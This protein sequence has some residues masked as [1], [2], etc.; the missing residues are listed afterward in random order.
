MSKMK[1]G[2][3]VN[4]AVFNTCTVLNTH[5]FSTNN[6]LTHCVVAVHVV[7]IFP[8]SQNSSEHFAEVHLKM[9]HTVYTSQ[10]FFVILKKRNAVV[11]HFLLTVL[12]HTEAYRYCID[13]IQGAA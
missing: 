3:T 12:Q 13:L 1:V 10:D 7:Y 8:A 11:N 4:S 2:L 9:K 5:S 6:R